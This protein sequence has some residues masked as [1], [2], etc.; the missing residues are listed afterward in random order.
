MGINDILA[1]ISIARAKAEDMSWIFGVDLS[2]AWL[3]RTH[4]ILRRYGP[5]VAANHNAEMETRRRRPQL[6][7]RGIK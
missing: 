5:N 2:T 7:W 4:D 3:A 6:D 1:A